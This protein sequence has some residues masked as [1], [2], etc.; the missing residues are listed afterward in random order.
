MKR[1]FEGYNFAGSYWCCDIKN[2]VKGVEISNIQDKGC[3]PPRRADD[4]ISGILSP[5]KPPYSK[6]DTSSL[7]GRKELAEE[8]DIQIKQ[9][10]DEIK[11]LKLAKLICTRKKSF[12]VTEEKQ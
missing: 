3:C 4:I 1:R 6:I 10:E 9:M 2:T 8:L 7:K 5:L 12:I 11:H